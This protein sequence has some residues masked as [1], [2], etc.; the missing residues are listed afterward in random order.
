MG[1]YEIYGVFGNIPRNNETLDFE[2]GN[3]W[4]SAK[5][6]PKFNSN[7]VSVTATTNLSLAASAVELNPLHLVG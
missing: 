1:A 2:I 7:D 6:G 4:A 5:Q 3:I